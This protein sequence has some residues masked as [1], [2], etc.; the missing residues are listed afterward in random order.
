MTK[1]KR[2]KIRRYLYV[3]FVIR[4]VPWTDIPLYIPASMADYNRLKKVNDKFYLTMY[5]FSYAE[6]QIVR[7]WYAKQGLRFLLDRD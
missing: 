6:W 3:H 7:G 5:G 4:D 1:H 2:R